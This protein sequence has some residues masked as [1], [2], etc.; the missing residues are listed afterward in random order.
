M[1][2]LPRPARR[3]IAAAAALFGAVLIAAAPPVAAYASRQVTFY[4][5]DGLRLSATWHEPRMRPAPAVVLVHMLN[6]S[7]RDWDVVASRLAME[8]IGALALDLRGHGE[9]QGAAYLSGP[10]DYE[11]FV[12]DVSAARRHLASRPDVQPGRVGIA[13]ASLGASLAV[14]AAGGDPPVRSLALLS[15]ALDYR[16]LR[17]EATARKFSGPILLVASDDDGYASRSVKDLQKAAGG[18]REVLMLNQ[19]GHGTVMLGRHPDLAGALVDWFRRT[20]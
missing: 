2:D 5:E 4:T 3:G 11:A 8:G 6:R 16:G 9:S 18:T 12:A 10:P 14:L 17:I 20:L 7:R 1:I 19:A 13:G 15:P